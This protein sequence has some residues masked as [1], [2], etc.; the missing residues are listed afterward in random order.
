MPAIDLLVR[1]HGPLLHNVFPSV[2]G[3]LRQAQDRHAPLLQDRQRFSSQ[4][5]R[6]APLCG[7]DE[8][9]VVQHR[10]RI[11]IGPAKLAP[12]VAT[13]FALAEAL[14]P[15]GQQLVFPFQGFQRPVVA[16]GYAGDDRLRGMPPCCRPRSCRTRRAGSGACRRRCATPARGRANRILRRRA[17][18]RSLPGRTGRAALLR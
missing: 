15:V 14:H 16:V 9:V 17:R 18:S 4:S 3:P 10:D 1:G 13:I 2:R 7:R 11:R 12:D 8:L 5:F 6:P